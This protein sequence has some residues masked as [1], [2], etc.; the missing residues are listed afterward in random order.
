[1]RSYWKEA[2]SSFCSQSCCWCCCCWCCC[3]HQWWHIWWGEGVASGSW[4]WRHWRVREEK[5][6]EE[7]SFTNS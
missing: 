1:L 6:R 2:I 5:V 7:S 4:V 3:R